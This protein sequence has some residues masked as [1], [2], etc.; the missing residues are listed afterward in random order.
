MGSDGQRHGP[1][2]GRIVG[3]LLL[4]LLDEF[5]HFFG[6][7]RYFDG[8]VN[9]GDFAFFINH[10]CGSTFD[11]QSRHELLFFVGKQREVELFLVGKLL[12]EFEGICTKA[13]HD[14]VGSGEFIQ[15]VPETA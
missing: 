12:L 1:N 15:E 2:V 13:N 8:G 3:L 4:Q 14:R 10:P 6:M 11:A 5:E 7:V 9:L